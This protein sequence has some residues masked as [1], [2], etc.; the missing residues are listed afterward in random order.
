MTSEKKVKTTFTAA[1]RMRDGYIDRRPLKAEERGEA[2]REVV[3]LALWVEGVT[4]I[5]VD[6][7]RTEV[8]ESGTAPEPVPGDE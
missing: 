2:W 6:E 5:Q 8:E 3:A 7:E 4:G 1:V